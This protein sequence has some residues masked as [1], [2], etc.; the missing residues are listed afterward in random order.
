MVSSIT[1]PEEGHGYI[2]EKITKPEKPIKS[3][4]YY[5]NYHTTNNTGEIRFKRDMSEYKKELKYYNEHKD[6]YVL[7]CSKNLAGKT[8]GFVE[9]KINVLFGPNGSGKSTI[10]KAIAGNAL[11]RDGFTKMAEPLVFGVGTYFQNKDIDDLTSYK[12]HCMGNDANVAW[13]GNPIY[14]NNFEQTLRNS[15]GTIGE[16]QGSIIQGTGEEVMFHTMKNKISAGEMATFVFRK[17][18]S[19]AKE[20]R[21]LKS[22]VYPEYDRCYK[23]CNETWQRVGKA[24]IDYFSSF[25]CWDKEM[26][27]TLLFDEIDKSLDITTV[28]TLYDTILPHILKANGCQIIIV[29]HSPIVMSRKIRESENYNI[30]SLDDEYTANVCETLDNLFN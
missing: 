25:P 2:F 10:L 9:N 6:E 30:I 5:R 29:S 3:S 7:R 24:Q 16:I 1:F 14:Y 22:I 19:M 21:S 17:I 23:K 11:V 15:R 18:L 13:D 4:A 12:A 26:P 20:K 8:F 27:I 28:A